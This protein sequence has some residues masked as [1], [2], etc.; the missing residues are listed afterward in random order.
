DQWHTDFHF[1]IT[2][3]ND[4]PEVS[5][6]DDLVI[7]EGGIAY[8]TTGALGISDPD[9]ATSESWLEGTDTLPGGGGDNFAVNHD[10]TGGNALKFVVTSLPDAA[11]GVL[12]YHNGTDWVAVTPGM[13][14][15]ASIITGS[16]GTTGLRYV[17][18]G[19]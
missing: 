8:I 17:H 7:P 15:D 3:V 18:N 4:A 19:S 1:Y 2:P 6:S 9:D 14:L 13:E 16:A 11:G 10:A 5:G 12:Q